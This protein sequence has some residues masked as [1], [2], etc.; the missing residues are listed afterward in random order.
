MKTTVQ[1]W[2]NSLAVRIPRPFADE[3]NL[4]ENSTI[5][6]SVRGGK[7]VIVPAEPDLTLEALV[8]AITDD[9]R[10]EELTTGKAVGR[11]IW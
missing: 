3:V 7:L 10:H 6:L 11:E 4:E 1:K 9:N 8:Q 5:D 2:G